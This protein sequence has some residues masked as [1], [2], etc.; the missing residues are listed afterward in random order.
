[1]DEH[2]HATAQVIDQVRKGPEEA[3]VHHKGV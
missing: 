3:T 1:M 2:E